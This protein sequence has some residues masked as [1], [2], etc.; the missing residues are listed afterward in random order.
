MHGDSME[1]AKKALDGILDDLHPH[2]RVTLIAF[3]DT[4]KVLSDR[5]L[6]CNKTNIGKARRFATELN[7]DM[8][9]TE[10]GHAL[11]AAY[12]AVGDKDSADI[13]LV[14]DGE[15][16][17]WE[18][19]VKKATRS[20]HRIFTVGVGCAV[21]EAFVRGLAANTGGECELVSPQEGMADL[22]IRHFERMRAPRAN[23]VTVHWPDGAQDIAPSSL[24]SVFQGDTVTAYA[25]FDH[26][27]ISG[28]VMLEVETDT[29]DVVRQEVPLSMAPVSGSTDRVSTVAR[30]AAAPRLKKLDE[31]AGL[32][33]ALHYRLVSP[34]TNLLVI[35]ER[36]EEEK[37][38]TLPA[39]RKVPHTMAAGWGG[40]GTVNGSRSMAVSA[41]CMDAPMFLRRDADPPYMDDVDGVG[42]GAACWIW[43]LDIPEPLRRLF[44]LIEDDPSKVEA[45]SALDLLREAGLASEFEDLFRQAADLGLT[46]EV[47]A[48]MVLAGLL[49]GPLNGY[50]PPNTQGAVGSLQDYV[51]RVTT[52][53][54]KMERRSSA[55]LRVTAGHVGREMLRPEHAQAIEESLTRV[56]KF[57]DLLDHVQVCIR[58]LEE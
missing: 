37:S 57:H 2:D 51:E 39:L 22:V 53:L 4:T 16:S 28:V 11:R 44:V 27:S 38:H 6:A 56:G 3:G 20:G 9:G 32:K 31:G 54:H 50:L 18:D 10:I 12:A 21:S 46:V 29:G 48:A 17:A 14:T 1:Q 55:L 19:V 35:A 42:T 15:V 43:D 34:W 13:F 25:R 41:S 33:T 30:V 7:A 8:G 40:M 36:S 45:K 52:A 58:R 24:G 47:I 49:G 26:P 5:L 23:R